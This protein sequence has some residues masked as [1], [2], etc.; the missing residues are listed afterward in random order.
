VETY[1]TLGEVWDVYRERYGTFKESS[2]LV[3]ST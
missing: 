2:Q 3:D 1:A